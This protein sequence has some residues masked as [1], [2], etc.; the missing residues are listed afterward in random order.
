MSAIG[1]F[2][3]IVSVLIFG[4][5][6]FWAFSLYNRLIKLRENCKKAWSNIDVLLKQR[7]EE[8]PKLIDTAKEYMDY[9]QETFQQVVEARQQV[10]EAG[11][12]KEEAEADSMLTSALG[13]FFA[14][15]EDYPELK[16][17][18]NFLQLQ[19]RISEIEDKIADRR[20]YYNSATTEYNA[21]IQQLPYVFIA[22]SMGWQQRELFEVSEEAK[23]DVDIDAMFDGDSE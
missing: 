1:V 7:S 2:A 22:N 6:V 23:E 10:Q 3:G 9:E 17:N 21:R 13:D 5:A 4:A 20:E 16:A 19:D 12:P 18:E 11:S 15:A 14:L 8:L